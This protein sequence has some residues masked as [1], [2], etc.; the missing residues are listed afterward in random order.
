VQG[1]E[2]D[3]SVTF[4]QG[5]RTCMGVTVQMTSSAALSGL[6]AAF[7]KWSRSFPGATISTSGRRLNLQSCDPGESA[8]PLPPITPSPFSV[9]ATRSQLIDSVVVDAKVPFATGQCVIDRVLN[10]LGPSKF[11]AVAN[12][13]AS[14]A[15]VDSLL[16]LV[17]QSALACRA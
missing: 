12:Q 4:E 2:G 7:E 15:H 16:Q 8:P 11:V 17:A 6:D 5:G 10:T 14:P 3:N 9:L 1:W 13:D